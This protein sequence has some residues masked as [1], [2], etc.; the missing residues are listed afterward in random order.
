LDTNSTRK[1]LLTTSM[2]ERK[3]EGQG[4][5]AHAER[6]GTSWASKRIMIG[7]WPGQKQETLSVAQTKTKRIGNV[8]QVA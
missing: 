2:S 7:G 6:V 4:T 1:T 5:V 3:K 8:A